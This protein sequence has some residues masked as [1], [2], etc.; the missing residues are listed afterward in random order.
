[1]CVCVWWGGGGGGGM[2]NFHFQEGTKACS[3]RGGGLTDRL[4]DGVSV[5]AVVTAACK[6]VLY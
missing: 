4:L 2:P 5:A 6:C 3:V 1:M